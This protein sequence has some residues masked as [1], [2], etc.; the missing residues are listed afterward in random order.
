MSQPSTRQRL[1]AYLESVGSTLTR[2][3]PAMVWL[4]ERSGISVH[5]LQSI[6]MG[7]RNAKLETR[8][9]LANALKM[10]ENRRDRA[11]KTAKG[12]KSA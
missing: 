7:R 6:G 3:T 8:I 5:T 1:L 11:A 10:A 12:R 2:T 4:S 9:A